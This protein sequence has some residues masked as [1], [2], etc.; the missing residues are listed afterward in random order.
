[1]DIFPNN[2]TW[3]SKKL[4]LETFL[5]QI[6]NTYS[7]AKNKIF[8]FKP[9][10]LRKNPLGGFVLQYEE[11]DWQLIRRI[12][13]QQ[14]LLLLAAPV[15]EKPYFYLGVNGKKDENLAK[16][17][18]Q[19]NNH[20]YNN[21]GK[22]RFP[23]PKI[24]YKHWKTDLDFDIGDWVEI[25]NEKWVICQ[26][27]TQL[28]DH[29]LVNNYMFTTEERMKPGKIYNEKICNYGNGNQDALCWSEGEFY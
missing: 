12:A 7:G 26:K 9:E 13:S 17:I 4:T 1:M 16:N 29:L 14:N 5:D 21:Q 28:E 8:T 24:A 18:R 22:F 10:T 15:G 23:N 3:Q 2:H 20:T 25:E 6:C 27:T 11:T 19:I